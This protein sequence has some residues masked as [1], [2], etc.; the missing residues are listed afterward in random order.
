VWQRRSEIVWGYGSTDKLVEV[1]IRKFSS[2]SSQGLKRDN[3]YFYFKKRGKQG[4]CFIQSSESQEMGSE[5]TMLFI[6]ELQ[7]PYIC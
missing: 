4:Q 3:F 7:P 2:S 6:G 1:G 5:W